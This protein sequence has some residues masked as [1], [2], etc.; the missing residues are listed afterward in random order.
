MFH[1]GADGGEDSGGGD[2]ECPDDVQQLGDGE[3]VLPS[4]LDVLRINP[5]TDPP[6]SFVFLKRSALHCGRDAGAHRP[7]RIH[8]G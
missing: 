5:V 8:L 7:A 2:A 3:V 1:R 6:R 4:G